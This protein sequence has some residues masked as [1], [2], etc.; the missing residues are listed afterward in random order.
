MGRDK[1]TMEFDGRSLWEPQLRVLREITPEKIFVSA[2]A[3]PAWLP[4]DAALLLDDRPSRGPLSGLTKALAAMRTTHLLA[5]AVDMPFM[6]SEQL[7]NLCSLAQA[8]LCV[9]PMIRDQAEPLAAIYAAEA[10]ADF[11]SALAGTDFSLQT[12]I[13]KLALQAKLR[14]F[15]VAPKDEHFY[16]SVNEPGDFKEGRFPNRPPK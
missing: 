6:T 13:R 7:R 11:A 1:A 9:V 3:R 12:I 14:L 15:A 10:A 5:L 8:G 2:R 16:R 4:D